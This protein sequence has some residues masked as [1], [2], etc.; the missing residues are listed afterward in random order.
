MIGDEVGLARMDQTCL[1]MSGGFA[2][3]SFRLFHGVRFGFGAGSVE[4]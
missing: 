2:P 1:A 3:T 4:L